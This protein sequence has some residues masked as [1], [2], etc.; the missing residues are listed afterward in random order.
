MKKII[1]YIFFA[2]S[3]VLAGCASTSGSVGL[4]NGSTDKIIEGKTTIAE[5]RAL[6]G[7]P[8]NAFTDGQTGGKV[9]SYYW[10]QSKV[11]PVPGLNN[12]ESK[13]LNIRFNK[14]GVVVAKDNGS[15]G[16]RF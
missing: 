2:F 5:V 16:S 10:S 11:Y 7:E 9:W 3:V 4:Q 1:A 14:N 8:A 13:S 12:T 6:L 15:S